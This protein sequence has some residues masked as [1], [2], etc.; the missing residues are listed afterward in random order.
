MKAKQ[1]GLFKTDNVVLGLVCRK[2]LVERFDVVALLQGASRSKMLRE[3]I[4]QF[5]KRMTGDENCDVSGI[6]HGLAVRAVQTFEKQ[7]KGQRESPFK[8][9]LI[10]LTADLKRKKIAEKYIHKIIEE[11]KKIHGE[12]SRV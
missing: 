11:T 6:L 8:Q 5:L 2:G 7:R 10:T 9:Y 4:V 3:A 12:N 1:L